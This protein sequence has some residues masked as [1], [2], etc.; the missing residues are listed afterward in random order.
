MSLPGNWGDVKLWGEPFNIND[1]PR[2]R[3]EL[4]VAPEAGTL[5]MFVRNAAQAKDYS[6]HYYPFEAG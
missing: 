5:Q 1:Y 3:I 2:Y 6:G 4:G